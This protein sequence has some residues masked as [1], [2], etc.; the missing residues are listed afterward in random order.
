MR[1]QLAA[2]R[3]SRGGFESRIN[4]GLRFATAAALCQDLPGMVG[5]R[6]N[7]GK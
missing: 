5:V 4:A 3:L 7:P 1:G 6:L 2:R